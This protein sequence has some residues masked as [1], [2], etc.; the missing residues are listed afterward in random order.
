[1]VPPMRYPTYAEIVRQTRSKASTTGT[2]QDR[3]G[4]VPRLSAVNGG[5]DSDGFV[6]Q[7]A[8]KRRRAKSD[9]EVSTCSP[10]FQN[11]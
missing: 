4:N 3:N 5:N 1:M 10:R 2:L 7:K 11:G 9:S 8:P 6:K